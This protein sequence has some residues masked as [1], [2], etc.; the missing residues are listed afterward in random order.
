MNTTFRMGGDNVRNRVWGRVKI[1]RV[2]IEMGG[3]RVGERIM[4]RVK[5]KRAKMGRG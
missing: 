4:G 2:K 5:I 1:Y 3:H